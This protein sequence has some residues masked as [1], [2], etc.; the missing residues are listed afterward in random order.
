MS[1]GPQ[2]TSCVEA[3]DFEPLSKAYV[4]VLLAATVG[5]A[6]AALFSAGIG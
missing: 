1:L 2:Y 3:A 5:G 6:I 4:A